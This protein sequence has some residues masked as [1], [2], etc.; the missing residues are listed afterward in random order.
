MERDAPLTRQAAALRRHVSRLL[1]EQGELVQAALSRLVTSSNPAAVGGSR[2]EAR[3]T[4]EEL[5]KEHK[6]LKAESEYLDPGTAFDGTARS[7]RC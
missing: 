1:R 2:D 6:R 5:W 4:T 7:N 3:P